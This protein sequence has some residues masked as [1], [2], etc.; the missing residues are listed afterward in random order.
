MTYETG[1]A[2]DVNPS[3]I[4]TRADFAAFLSQ[5][6]AAATRRPGQKYLIHDA[7]RPPTSAATGTPA[8]PEPLRPNQT[9]KRRNRRTEP[10][11]RDTQMT[12]TDHNV[13]DRR[14]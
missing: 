2:T 13:L 9:K 14:L 11:A 1:R 12:P 6:L 7:R 10:L 8:R 5:L 4:A 3:Y